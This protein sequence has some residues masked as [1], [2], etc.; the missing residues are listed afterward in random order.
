MDVSSIYI[1]YTWAYYLLRETEKGG[2]K[3]MYETYVLFDGKCHNANIREEMVS[4]TLWIVLPTPF[5]S[6]A[7]T[8]TFKK[9]LLKKSPSITDIKNIKIIW[10][11]QQHLKG[12]THISYRD[13]GIS[14]GLGHWWVNV[15]LQ[16]KYEFIIYGNMIPNTH[17]PFTCKSLLRY[18]L[19]AFM[20]AKL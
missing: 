9:L 20:T 19:N 16:F 10:I 13:L 12:P 6:S 18:W 2:G 14:K 11:K 3:I 4:S 5:E 1:N 8:C 17:I 15:K 7:L